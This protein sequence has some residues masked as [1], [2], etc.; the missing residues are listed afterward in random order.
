VGR[1]VPGLKSD[2]LVPYSNRRLLQNTLGRR[3]GS[4]RRAAASSL[5]GLCGGRSTR[6]AALIDEPWSDSAQRHTCRQGFCEET[7]QRTAQPLLQSPA[8]PGVGC[9]SH[10]FTR[11]RLHAHATNTLAHTTANQFKIGPLKISNSSYD[12]NQNKIIRKKSRS[13]TMHRDRT[14][15]WVTRGWLFSNALSK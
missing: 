8:V 7:E 1:R 13:L 4:L 6:A 11:T 2:R 9:T 12:C 3:G 5:V 14:S 15:Q 10:R